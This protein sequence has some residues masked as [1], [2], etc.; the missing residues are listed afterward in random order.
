[1]AL[2]LLQIRSRAARKTA[3]EAEARYRELFRHNPLP[4]WLYDSQTLQFIAVNEAAVNQYGYSEQEFLRMTLEDIRAE[5]NVAQLNARPTNDAE[6][7]CW[8][9]VRHRRKDG[10][11]LTVNVCS[12]DMSLRGRPARLAVIVDITER[13]RYENERATKNRELEQAKMA[14]ESANRFKSEFLANMS[15]EIRTPMNAIIGMTSLLLEGPVSSDQREMLDIV[16]NS[17][18]ALMAIINDI[19]DFSKIEAGKLTLDPIVF[20]IEDAMVDTLRV[21]GPR[22]YGKGIELAL[23]ISPK[24]PARVK[25]DVG[26]LR[27][28]LLNL[29][30]NSVKFTETG[31][32]VLGVDIERQTGDSVTLHF[33]VRD[34][35]PGIAADKLHEIFAPFTQ[36]DSSVQ[37]RFGGTGLGLSIA[38]R[39]TELMGGRIWAE[40]EPGRGSTFHFTAVLHEVAES[41]KE[42]SE[43]VTLSGVSVLVVQD[44]RTARNVLVDSLR[45]WG[46]RVAYASDEQEALAELS[47]AKNAG[48]P[49]VLAILD[50]HL[51]SANCFTVAE[52]IRAYTDGATRIV[53]LSPFGQRGDA[54]RC[55]EVGISGYLTKPVK[56]TELLACLLEVLKSPPPEAERAQLVTRHSLREFP[57]SILV[58]EDNIVNQRLTETLLRKRGHNV[59]IA[60]NGAEALEA[61]SREDFDVVLMDLHMPVM[62][63]LEATTAIRERERGKSHRSKIIALTADDVNDHQEQWRNA[64]IDG[65]LSKPISPEE[66]YKAV[67]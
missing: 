5:D 23:R 28:I 44:S 43:L 54:A 3:Q 30:G 34:T 36:A 62:D 55:R 32:V 33:S 22:A 67:S 16:F 59:V 8:P 13:R 21:L 66:L 48:S 4:A 47:A 39:L 46:M 52:R 60:K 58:A 56:G 31:E 6:R 11:L 19:L 26:R 24:I 38:Q 9:N 50:L 15:H 20:N 63:G 7:Q 25:G 41:P 27:Q 45:S 53:L 12:Y 17:S 1:M 29:I 42:S 51:L 37:R 57:R 18:T 49:I 35:G 2:V 65:C 64:G 14:A 10:A 40:S 61:L